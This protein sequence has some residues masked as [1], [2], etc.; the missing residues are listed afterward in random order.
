[1]EWWV[2]IDVVVCDDDEEGW[3]LYVWGKLDC[4]D[5][6]GLCFVL[7]GRNLDFYL[8]MGVEGVGELRLWGGY[9]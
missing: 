3:I 4:G 8:M 1:M 2:L 6:C 9:W 5:F 7:K